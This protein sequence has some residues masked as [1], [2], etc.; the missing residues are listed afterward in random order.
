MIDV[1]PKTIHSKIASFIINEV[2]PRSKKLKLKP[3]EFLDPKISTLLVQ[4]EDSELTFRKQTREYLDYFIKR[5]S[6]PDLEPSDNVLK[7]CKLLEI[8]EGYND[9]L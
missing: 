1:V 8:C 5:M 6:N 9:Q 7:I 4:L 3:V 2:L